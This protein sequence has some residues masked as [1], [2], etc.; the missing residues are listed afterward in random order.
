[1]RVCVYVCKGATYKN[2]NIYVKCSLDMKQ[3][4]EQ[5]KK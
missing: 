2:F 1:M 5:N 3:I 4:G